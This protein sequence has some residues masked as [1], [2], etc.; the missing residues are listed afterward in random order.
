MRAPKPGLK[1]E[2]KLIMKIHT[3]LSTAQY[4]RLSKFS[5]DRKIPLAKLLRDGA[6]KLTEERAP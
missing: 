6:M 4:E 1:Y 5:R 2:D 3:K